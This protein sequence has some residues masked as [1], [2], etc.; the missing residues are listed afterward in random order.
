MSELEAYMKAKKAIMLILAL[1]FITAPILNASA[2]VDPKK[3]TPMQLEGKYKLGASASGGSYTALRDGQ[4]LKFDSDQSYAVGDIVEFD[5]EP[6][7]VISF[8]NCGAA[9]GSQYATANYY[10]TG[11]ITDGYT[12]TDR[13]YIDYAKDTP[14]YYAYKM[15]EIVSPI[16][17]PREVLYT[18]KFTGGAEGEFTL[19]GETV[20][21]MV[22]NGSRVYDPTSKRYL[23]VANWEEG[24]QTEQAP[25]VCTVSAL[26]G[27]IEWSPTGERNTW[28]LLQFGERLPENAHIKTDYDSFVIISFSDMSTYHMK[29][30]SHIV[31]TTHP[32]THRSKLSIVAGRVWVSVKKMLETGSMEVEMNQAVAGIKGTTFVCEE[33]DGKST[34]KVIEGTVEFTSK[35]TGEA[36]MVE[37]GQQILADAVGVAELTSFDAAAEDAE[38]AKLAT[39]AASASEALVTAE[40]DRDT[41]INSLLLLIAAA[42]V[43]III[44]ALIF[45]VVAS[46]KK[47]RNVAAPAYVTQQ[48][49]PMPPAGAAF[50]P[51]CGSSVTA[52]ASFCQKCGK[53]VG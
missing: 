35:I 15:D 16:T 34:L 50:C 39:Q 32:D 12:I 31:L 43:V 3:L 53:V 14:P 38:W 40:P 10:K 24:F 28:K 37:G 49:L 19:D 46:Q 22:E 33:I 36:I 27:Q 4:L 13:V 44:V 20:M 21:Y 2:A 8:A 9:G 51:Q 52:G 41:G 42:V 48:P 5:Y 17:M 47:K 6:I 11:I 26:S 18:Y 30:D 25:S 1:L 23:E 45:A 29:E 7:W